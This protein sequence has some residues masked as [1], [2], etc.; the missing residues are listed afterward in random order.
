[1][2]YNMESTSSINSFFNQTQKIGAIFILLMW[3]AKFGENNVLDTR[4]KYPSPRRDR[5]V[6]SRDRD[7]EAD[8]P[9]IAI[10][11]RYM[12]LSECTGNNF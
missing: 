4:H 1:M 12:C 9:R 6:A 11:V 8:C 10:S 3:L 7:V 5:D 2:R